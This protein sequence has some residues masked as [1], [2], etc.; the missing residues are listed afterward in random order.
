MSLT[1]IFFFVRLTAT[2][3]FLSSVSTS[4]ARLSAP[5][6]MSLFHM[7]LSADQFL[8]HLKIIV[9]VQGPTVFSSWTKN[10]PSLLSMCPDRTSFFFTTK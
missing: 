1:V 3:R 6:R 4:P 2:K 9:G 10:V 8:D 5:S 7:A